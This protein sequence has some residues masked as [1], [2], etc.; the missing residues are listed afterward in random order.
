MQQLSRNF[1]SF[2]K[3]IIALI[4]LIVFFTLFSSS[5]SS[6]IKFTYGINKLKTVDDSEIEKY[7]LKYQIP[8]QNCFVLDPEYVNYINS[9]NKTVY[10][11]VNFFY[12]PLQL[13]YFDKSEKL[14]SYFVNCNAGGWP[15]LKWNRNHNFEQFPPFSNYNPEIIKLSD[16]TNYIKPLNKDFNFF[17]NY[18]NNS[19]FVVIIFWNR[20][21]GR[22]TKKFLKIINSNLN[23]NK[24]TNITVFY[25]NN[26]NF[27]TKLSIN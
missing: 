9:I 16:I 11:E 2:A 20:F 8:L 25:V 15:N 3:R 26:D 7:C 13:M 27:L 18:K 24:N 6:I 4:F 12:Q 17:K 23:L 1:K 21:M 19:D 10:T 22:Q 14:I 5:C